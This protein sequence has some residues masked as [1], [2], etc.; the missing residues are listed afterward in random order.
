MIKNLPVRA[1]LITSLT[2]PIL[3]ICVFAGIYFWQY[4]K[5]TQETDDAILV[6]QQ[7]MSI[8]AL[9]HEIQAERGLSAALVIEPYARLEQ[10]VL[11]Q[12]IKTDQ[13]LVLFNQLLQNNPAI[14]LLAEQN[15]ID[16][17]QQIITMLR[18]VVDSGENDR[19]ESYTQLVAG[20]LEFVSAMQKHVVNNHSLVDLNYYVPLLWFKEFA[21]LERGSFNR[22]YKSD[23]FNQYTFAKLYSLREKQQLIFSQLQRLIP[24]SFKD[25]LERITDY[26]R[27]G[28]LNSMLEKARYESQKQDVLNKARSYFGLINHYFKGYLL[29]RDP[30][31]YQQFMN[32][33]Q[34]AFNILSTYKS[35]DYNNQQMQVLFDILEQYKQVVERLDPKIID[36][37][38]VA[39]IDADFVKIE[40]LALESIGLIRHDVL[41]INFEDWWLAATQRI[42]IIDG[43]INSTS[44][45]YIDLVMQLK[46]DK[47]KSLFFELSAIFIVVFIGVVFAYR[48]IHQVLQELQLFAVQMKAIDSASSNKRLS[49]H[50]D[51]HLMTDVVDTFNNIVTSMDAAQHDH[52]L[53]SAFFNSAGEGMVISDKSNHIEMI[54]PAFTRMTGFEKEDLLGSTILNLLTDKFDNK[55][56]HKVIM[57]AL[58]N[59]ESWE[60]EV[61]IRDKTDC[62][63]SVFLSVAAVKD[64]DDCI[65]H[66]IYLL[67]NLDKW[68][69]HE[70]EIWV[71][72]NFDSLTNLPNRNMGLEKL[73]QVVE[74]SKRS[75][76]IAAVMF[77]DLDNFKIINDSLGHSAGDELLCHVSERLRKNIRA[78]DIVCRLGGDEFVVI[79]SEIKH[80][81]EV[82]V[83]ADKLI[84][85][86]SKP[87]L[88]QNQHEG[89]IS[90]SIGITLTPNDG[91]DVEILLRNADIAMYH[92]KDLGRNNSQFYT[93][94]LNQKI[95]A[96]MEIEQELRRGLKRDEF[97]SHYQPIF[98]IKTKEIIGVEALIR[99]QHHEKGLIYPG[100]FIDIAEE[101]GI[102]IDFGNLMISQ[103][104]IQLH[105]WQAQG[106]Y[107]HAA[108]NLSSKQFSPEHAENLV[109]LISS[110]LQKYNIAG[111]YLHIEI[112]ERVF[113]KNIDLVTDTLVKLRNL[114]IKIHLDDFGT[115]YS[116][117]KYLINFPVDY[118]KID[119][120]FI[121]RISDNGKARK[122][123]KTI[124][125]MTSELELKVVAEGIE[126]QKE[127]EFLAKLGCDYG[128]GYW[129]ASAASADELVL[130]S[131]L[132]KGPQ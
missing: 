102:V 9:V 97:I 94:Q 45:Q 31:Y 28:K 82:K 129:F 50:S 98:A 120:S 35:M 55:L 93:Q 67:K 58:L 111:E 5:S 88:L 72:A 39:K 99:W 91:S 53:S 106:I 61:K 57:Q 56:L 64:K 3:L 119:R 66:Y 13:Q 115:G 132:N 42:D 77:I 60:S 16:N 90:A 23:N 38:Q 69:K 113:M 62:Y 76:V 19:F 26:T 2:I 126:N 74:H 81:S 40:Y 108:V 7:S 112:T 25:D 127:Y 44:E 4:I 34:D 105:T 73:K 54:N 70:E 92:A 63:R 21:G 43:I 107:I 114:G 123:I 32:Q 10:Q 29:R 89:F 59:S 118:L 86:I 80:V 33:Y 100:D 52:L 83:L 75:G 71:K 128:Q 15:D 30:I 46:R 96:R 36:K 78:T 20:N 68:K 47:Y 117:L 22:I 17:Q 18:K 14:N 49:I 121:S 116:S 104:L 109:N 51:S 24:S 41:N 6:I 122:V 11:K 131:A 124:V 103:T 110:E 65:S 37:T 125:A 130:P 27:N 101:T 48:T 87:Y 8:N 95:T 1:K 85:E 84:S 12:R 79:V